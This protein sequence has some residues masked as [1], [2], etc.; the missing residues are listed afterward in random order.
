MQ[1]VPVRLVDYFDGR[2]QSIIPLFQRPY[3]W[4]HSNWETLW[5]DILDCYDESGKLDPHFMDAVVSLPVT[6]TPIGVI[7]YLIIDGQQ[8]LTTVSILLC[9]L[10]GFLDEAVK[11]RI[12]DFLINRHDKGIDR[13]KL[14]PTQADRAT[15]ESLVGEK[16][17][18]ETESQLFKASQYFK[19][20]LS[21]MKSSDSI[22]PLQILEVIE[23][24]LRV[25]MISLDPEHEDPYEIFESLNFKGTPLTPGDLVRNFIL[26]KYRH[27]IGD[28]GEQTRIYNEYWNPIE[29]N[30]GEDLPQFLMHYCRLSGREVRKKSVYTS[31]KSHI[32]ETCKAP[33]GKTLDA[34]EAG[35]VLEQELIRMKQASAIYPL[36]LNPDRETNDRIARPLNVLK[37]LGVTVFYPLLMRLFVGEVCG[38]ITREELCN[39]LDVLNAFLIRRAVCNLKN[40]ALDSLTTQL[41]KDW[42]EKRPATFLRDT[43]SKQTG[44][45]RWPKDK[46][47]VESFIEDPQYG[48]KSTQWVLWQLE[49]SH[50]H[51]EGL[52][53]KNIQTE[54]ILPQTQSTDWIQS[55]S[56][57]DKEHIER[58]IDTYGN[59]TLTGYNPE[60]SN[61]GFTAKREIYAKSHF[62]I[63]KTIASES[64]W[65][66]ASIRRRGEALAQMALKVWS[67][68]LAVSETI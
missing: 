16:A 20:K 40:N 49:E 44:N 26:M 63:N 43:L 55:L 35:I 36:L 67:G 32:E 6:T 38:T 41:L 33:A 10:R 21:T 27:S 4:Q 29:M 31:F 45:L 64:S 7:K 47:F 17:E 66:I 8:R 48:R 3:T 25:V 46:E 1:T 34:D 68:P 5:Q 58:W 11:D 9:V 23:S 19:K 53:P 65:S 13:Y 51:K 62:E 22:G 60:L 2:K 15:Y 30:C 18:I 56:E 54:H 37:I 28:D 42:D 59:L 57:A 14:A 61:R 52:N 12:Q 50:G 39:S 24:A